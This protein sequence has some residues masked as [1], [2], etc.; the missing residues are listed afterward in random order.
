VLLQRELR[1]IRI[2]LEA[3]VFRIEGDQRTR[4]ATYFGTVPAAVGTPGHGAALGS[5]GPV[6][7]VVR[8]MLGG[9]GREVSPHDER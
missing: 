5:P 4:V 1:F 9:E 7:V 6:N 8:V 3:T 2:E